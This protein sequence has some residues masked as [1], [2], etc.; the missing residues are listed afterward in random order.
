MRSFTVILRV[1]IFFFNGSTY[2][3]TL[4]AVDFGLATKYGIETNGLAGTPDYM[5]R[6]SLIEKCVPSYSDDLESIGWLLVW[7]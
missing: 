2:I 7:T 6:R 5:S 1:T 4:C 3:N